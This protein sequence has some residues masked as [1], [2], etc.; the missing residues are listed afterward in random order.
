MWATRGIGAVALAAAGAAYTVGQHPVA[1]IQY[2]PDG[3]FVMV[4]V[5]VAGRTEL[6][7]LDT[8]TPNLVIDS[9]LASRIKL[10]VKSAGTTTGSGKGDVA[11]KH[12]V[13]LAVRVGGIR[14]V[15]NDPL[16]VDLSGV[17]IDQR[18]R[19][20]VGIDLWKRY[21]VEINPVKHTLSLYNPGNFRA[22]KGSTCIPLTVEKNRLFVDVGLDVKAGQSVVHRV[23]VDTGADESVSD[24]IFAEA[25]ETRR[26]RLGNGL[27][28][29]YYATSG[30]IDA[31]HLGPFTIRSVWG[32]GGPVPSMG[33]EILRRF[34]TTIDVEHNCLHLTATPALTDPV[35]PPPTAK[36]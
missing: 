22:A 5:R 25:T 7:T 27:G 20:L 9:R 21:V 18:V 26:S 24:P 10:G 17:P 35:P 11:I 12:A 28:E 15:S 2:L 19:G 29:S 13:P 33:M 34:V 8:S 4:P 36:E 30:K 16:I 32:P 14:L 1:V 31:L 23:R 6:F 3:H